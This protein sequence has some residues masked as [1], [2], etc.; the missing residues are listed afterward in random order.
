MRE[1]LARLERTRILVGRCLSYGDGIAYWPLAEI[2]KGLAGISDDDPADPGVERV[3]A[4]AAELLPDLRT[5]TAALAFTV[6]LDTSDEEFARLQPS[7]LRVELTAPGARCSRHS[8]N[9]S[10]SSL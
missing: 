2:L 7:A 5:R 10:R 3:E 6:C 8:Q 4:L 9:V 1:L